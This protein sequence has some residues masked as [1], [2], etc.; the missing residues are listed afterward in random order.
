MRPD[1]RPR[2][3]RCAALLP[4]VDAILSLAERSGLAFERDG[5]PLRRRPRPRRKKLCLSTAAPTAGDPAADIEVLGETSGQLG[6]EVGDDI[7]RRNHTPRYQAEATLT[8][9]R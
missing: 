5:W 2:R 3:R 4:D 6:N 9:Q 8:V 1:R 7:P